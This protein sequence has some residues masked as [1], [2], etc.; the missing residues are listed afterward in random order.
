MK[1]EW[2]FVDL[3]DGKWTLG[4]NDGYESQSLGF[5]EDDFDTWLYPEEM[6]IDYVINVF[7][8]SLE[9]KFQFNLYS[10]PENWRDIVTNDGGKDGKKSILDIMINIT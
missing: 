9:D 3:L 4:F 6:G 1:T 5:F 8:E 7:R 2:L 10:L